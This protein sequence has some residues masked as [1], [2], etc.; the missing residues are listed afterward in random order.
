MWIKRI[1]TMLSTLPELCASA[2]APEPISIT[3]L[4]LGG[5]VMV[6]ISPTSR[7][8]HAWESLTYISLEF[9]YGNF[10]TQLLDQ[11]L[12]LIPINKNPLKKL[13]TRLGHS[14]IQS[15]S[16]GTIQTLSRKLKEKAPH[17]HVIFNGN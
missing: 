3:E 7:T 1:V 14:G 17:S 13:Q 2:S 9:L 4:I 11:G 16:A 5:S 8:S 12:E 10:P 6:N 15:I